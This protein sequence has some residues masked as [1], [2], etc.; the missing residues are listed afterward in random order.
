MDIYELKAAIE[1]YLESLMNFQFSVSN[2][3]FWILLLVLFLILLRFWD[4]RK[5]FSFCCIVAVLLLAT[6][7][8][9]V[10]I[11]GFVIKSSGTFDP[12][13]IR[14]IPIIVLSFIL[15]YYIF[16]KERP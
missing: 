6:T 1:P 14:T 7:K 9:E 16:I 3:L 15:I 10:L 12:F 11:A 4:I 2:P 8:A 13:L 5:S